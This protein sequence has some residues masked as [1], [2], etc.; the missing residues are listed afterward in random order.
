MST[1]IPSCLSSLVAENPNSRLRRSSRLRGGRFG[2]G[3]TANDTESKTRQF[4]TVI[5]AWNNISVYSIM[6]VKNCKQIFCISPK[7]ETLPN[8]GWINNYSNSIHHLQKIKKIKNNSYWNMM[9]Y[10]IPA[11][12]WN[13]GND[14][15]VIVTCNWLDLGGS[16]VLGA[17]TEVEPSDLGVCTCILFLYSSNVT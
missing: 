14:G 17:L 4:V 8:R 16:G 1:C 5:T 15:R 6:K 7:S 11:T 13:S 2:G 12:S 10:A 3:L 9:N